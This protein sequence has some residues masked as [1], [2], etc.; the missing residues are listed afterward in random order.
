VDARV[1][2]AAGVGYAGLV[3]LARLDP[4]RLERV[5]FRAMNGTSGGPVPALRVPQQLGTPW[6]LPGIAVAGFLTTAHT[7]HSRRRSHC[8]WRRAWRWASS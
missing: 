7:W 4:K 1:A 3:P 6:L 5:A 8:R 2:L